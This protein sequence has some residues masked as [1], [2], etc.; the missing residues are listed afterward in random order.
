MGRFF[1]FL[2]RPF[3]REPVRTEAESEQLRV[4]FKA[5][6]HSFK[7]LLDAN[8]KVLELMAELGENLR[9]TRPYGMTYI[10][11]RCTRLATRV[12]QMVK[13][14]N[15]RAPGEYEPLRERFDSIRAQ[16]NESFAATPHVEREGDLVLPLDR[17]GSDSADQ[18][19][20]KMATLGELRRL[21][22]LTVPD[23]FVVTASGF[24]AFMEHGQLQTEIDRRLQ[25]A[26]AEGLDDFYELSTQIQRLIRGA[27]IPD[28]LETAILEHYR[29]L[30]R[31]AGEGISVA[32]RSSSL[33]EDIPGS[34]FA[35][36][37][38]SETR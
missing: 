14:L 16:V 20:W 5:R 23:G 25:A 38:H 21:P 34:T 3:T 29:L 28:D 35:G 6:Y 10:R 26:G 33:D 12:W 13:H 4:D 30:E 17:I 7:L 24:R 32:V 37:H 8:S 18:V 11:A 1:D 22:D 9:G 19:G 2:K 36:Q 15:D 31:T 27:A